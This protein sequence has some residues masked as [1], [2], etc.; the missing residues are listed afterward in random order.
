VSL[1]RELAATGDALWFTPLGA[2]EAD[3]E[4]GV[5]VALPLPLSG[6]EEPVGW[7]MRSD[8]QPSPGLQ[9]VR[10]AVREQAQQRQRR[11]TTAR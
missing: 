6:T 1:G 7:L 8:A 10:A 5:L 2:A 3:L 11:W 4:R 9:A